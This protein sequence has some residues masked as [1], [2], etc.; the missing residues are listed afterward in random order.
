MERVKHS[1]QLTRIFFVPIA[2]SDE[3]KPEPLTAFLFDP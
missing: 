2:N 1:I 3:L